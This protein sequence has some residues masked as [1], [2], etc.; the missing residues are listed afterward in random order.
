MVALFVALGGAS[1]AAIIIPHNSIGPAQ[2]RNG[3]VTYTKIVPG[4]VGTV[5]ANTRQLQARVGGKCN[6]GAAIGAID[7]AGKVTCNP[8][9]PNEYAT[10]SSQTVNATPVT[11]ATLNLPA[12]TSYLS[13]A[14]PVADVS[15]T[16]AE[17]VQLQCTLGDGASSQTR[18]L[19][20]ET[21]AAGT[22]KHVSTSLLVAG[23]SGTSALSCVVVSH[24][25]TVD[26][27]VSVTA[28]INAIQTASNN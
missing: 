21:D 24:T 23:P 1:Y 7:Q 19:S 9:L 20:V 5:R 22:V 3:S 10:S 25:G 27:T 12:G 16:A 13:I 2:L 28:G 15:A 6:A 11:V 4:A 8:A 18:N 17:T 26:P 14:N